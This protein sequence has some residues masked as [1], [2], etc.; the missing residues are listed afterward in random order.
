M[1]FALAY[2]QGG[3][4]QQLGI[5]KSKDIVKP[6]PIGTFLKQKFKTGGFSAPE[7]VEASKGVQ[8][9]VGAVKNTTGLDIKKWAKCGR[10]GEQGE[11]HGNKYRDLMRKLGRE[12]DAPP[13]YAQ[14]IPLWDSTCNEQIMDECHFILP[15]EQID[16]MVTK[17]NMHEFTEIPLGS[18]LKARMDD[19]KQREGL[20]ADAPVVGIGV[21]GDRAPYG[22]RDS[23]DVV[24]FNII[25]GIHH[26]RI[27]FAAFSKRMACNCGCAGRCTYDAIFQV[28]LWSLEI[29]R[30]HIFPVFRADGVAFATSKYTGDKIRAGWA[31][32]KKRLRCL[33]LCCRFG[34]TGNGTSKY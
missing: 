3:V 17:E 30:S 31:K 27:W 11:A 4:K 16:S 9:T 10:G 20:A 8:A 6:T 34:A 14:K 23:L 24:L 1:A 29:L 15:H 33:G 32:F 22:T 12:S 19:W 18:P 13:I 28:L 7:I 5:S 26:Y 25:S 21:W 2:L